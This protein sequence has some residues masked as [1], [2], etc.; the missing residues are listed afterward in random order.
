MA[1]NTNEGHHFGGTGGG[2]FT[3]LRDGYSAGLVEVDRLET[4]D[5]SLALELL[6]SLGLGSVTVSQGTDTWAVLLL[7]ARACAELGGVPAPAPSPVGVPECVVVVYRPGTATRSARGGARVGEW[8]T[9]WTDAEHAAAV[10]TVRAAIARGE[11]YQANVVGHRSAP[12]SGDPGALAEA[13]AA[14]PG[15]SYGGVVTGD[16]WAVASASPEQLVRVVGDRVTTVP[17]KGTSRDRDRL[18]TSAKD[19][20]E[21]VMIVDLERN[22]L[23]RVTRAGSVVVEELYA[24]SEWAGLWH[25]SSLVSGRLREGIGTAEVLR[26]LVPGGS[27]TGAPKHAA[28]GLL[29]DLEPVGRGPAMGAFGVLGPGCLDLGLTIRTVALADGTAHLWAGGGITWGSDPAAEVAEAHAKA[30][31]VQAALAQV[32]PSAS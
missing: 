13:V 22:D 23:A 18:L 7:G 2:R 3:S 4:H 32:R 11:V 25:A 30:A 9:S 31:P 5:P 12:Y 15:A 21:H 20:A 27:V 19:R 6:D 16:G 29:A 17:I 10:E 26:A 8:R 24:L 1:L 14:M 28:C